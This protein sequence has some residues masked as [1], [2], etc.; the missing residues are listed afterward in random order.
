MQQPARGPELT[1]SPDIAVDP[2]AESAGKPG[3]EVPAIAKWTSK[4]QLRL[5]PC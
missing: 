3:I 4:R 1:E 2:G 5:R